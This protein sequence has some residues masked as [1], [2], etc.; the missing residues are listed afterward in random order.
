MEQNGD[1]NFDNNDAQEWADAYCQMGLPVA[2]S[3]LEVA[4]GDFEGSGL[5]ADIARRGIA[6]AEAVALVLGRGSDK[7]AEAF[8]GAPEADPSDAQALLPDC[9]RL[10]DAI[11][12]GPD[13]QPPAALVE[14][15][16]RLKGETPN[17]SDTPVVSEEPARPRSEPV[18]VVAAETDL[19]EIRLAIAN[20]SSDMDAL[21][22]ELAE[23]IVRLE[24][25]IGGRSL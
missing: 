11:S 16:A 1:H 20:L 21:R 25:K 19:E 2:A 22:R 7:A 12:G 6:A 10:I 18:E 13:A 23:G 3:T 5:T 14:L 24:Q 17:I 15:K 9:M 4:L 8:A